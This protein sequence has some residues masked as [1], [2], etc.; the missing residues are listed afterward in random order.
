M[1]V[2]VNVV[3]TRNADSVVFKLMQALIPPGTGLSF[4][5]RETAQSH[6]IAKAVFEVQG[7]ASVWVIGSEIQVTKD[8]A[9][10][11]GRIKGKVV[12]AIKRAIPS[13]Q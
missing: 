5:N 13:P 11:W 1:S 8:P 3:P 12:A 6:P 10:S 7:V 2:T 9:V 4:P